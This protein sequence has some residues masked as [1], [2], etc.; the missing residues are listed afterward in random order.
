MPIDYSDYIDMSLFAAAPPD[1]YL[2][3]LEYARLTIPEL[4]IRQGTPEDAVLQAASYITS[5]N[6]SAINQ[7]P[8][9]LMSGVLALLGAPRDEG[10]FPLIEVT[11][12]AATHA[13]A[14]VEAGTLVRYD[15]NFTDPPISVY[16]ETTEE[17]VI[18]PVTNTG[19][20]PLPTGTVE[21][22]GNETL[23]IFPIATDSAL[24][25]ESVN[26]DVYTATLASITTL[27]RLPESDSEYLKRATAYIGSLSS[28]FGKASQIEAYILTS[29]PDVQR[30]KVYDL[31]DPGGDLEVGEADVGG[32]ITVFTYGNG[33]NL[34]SERKYEIL[35][36]VSDRSIAGLQI[37]VNDV[38]LADVGI[39]VDVTYSSSYTPS[40]IEENI[41]RS[42]LSYLNPNSY[43]FV[44]LIRKSSLFPSIT[45]VPGVEFVSSLT[46]TW[47]GMPVEYTVNTDG[48]LVIPYKGVL[49]RLS[50]TKITVNLT[51]GS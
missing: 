36:D 6:L 29:F 17:L 50:D 7:L 41:E 10:E 12:T 26:A 16:F 1:I 5:Q 9:R 8:N 48:D 2:S 23:D 20:T 45:S 30:V 42:L 19:T 11:F 35:V 13:G 14:T 28:S 15:Y 47:E 37:G 43:P 49:P 3:A 34:S 46:L 33:A 27:G 40:I 21:A 22:R 44:T 51:L 25:I 24:Q 31:T 32:K 4:T 18:D 38:V 39:T